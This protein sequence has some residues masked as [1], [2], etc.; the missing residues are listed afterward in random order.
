[1]RSTFIT[2]IKMYTEEGRRKDKGR[3]KGSVKQNTKEIHR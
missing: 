2:R 1:M 3:M